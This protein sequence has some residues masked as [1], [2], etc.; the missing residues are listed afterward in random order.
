MTNHKVFAIIIGEEIQNIIVAE[1]IIIADIC[2]KNTSENAFAIDC[3]D[4]PCSIGDFYIGTDFY[5]K[6][7]V[8]IIPSNSF[9]SVLEDLKKSKDKINKELLALSDEYKEIANKFN[10]LLKS[11]DG[12]EKALC[13]LSMLIVPNEGGE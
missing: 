1:N 10:D 2:A 7:K 3:T 5:F 11:K 4:Y 12:I 9:E 6:D 13:E 8:T